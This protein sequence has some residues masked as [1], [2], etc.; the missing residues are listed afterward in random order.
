[1]QDVETLVFKAL[2]S[3]TVLI[4]LLG[5]KKTVNNCK[6]DRIY[7]SKIALNPDEY[8][9]VTI[10]EVLNEDAVYGDNNPQCSDVNIRIDLWTKDQSIVF[11]ICKQIKQTLLNSFEICEVKL[12]SKMFEEDTEVHHKPINVY[13]LLEQGE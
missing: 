3:D 11:D 4:N 8:P 7:N 13:L 2:D 9:R 6:W 1:M 12:E 5:G 10:Y